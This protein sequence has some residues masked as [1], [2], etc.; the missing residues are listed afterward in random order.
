M[1][2]SSLDF[3]I[4]SLVIAL[5]VLWLTNVILWFTIPETNKYR[6]YIFIFSNIILLALFTM[7][8]YLGI[9]PTSLAIQTVGLFYLILIILLLIASVFYAVNRQQNPHNMPQSIQQA[10]AHIDDVIYPFYSKKE[11]MTFEDK[12]EAMSA[13]VRQIALTTV[14]TDLES[15]T[16]ISLFELRD[17]GKFR[18]LSTNNI[19]AHRISQLE[20]HFQYAPKSI[21][22]VGKCA[23]EKT[24]I[25]RSDLTN[26]AAR[27]DANW[28]PTPE[29]DMPHYSAKS[30]IC[31]PVLDKD[32]C[33]AVISIS[34]SKR[35]YFTTEHQHQL[36]RYASSARNLLI[37]LNKSLLIDP[38]EDY[39]IKAIT[40]S[41]EVGSG[42][43]TLAAALSYI[44]PSWRRVS[45]GDRF[46]R[47]CSDRGLTEQHINQ[48]PDEIHREFDEYQRLMLQQEE[49]IILESRLS[50]YLAAEMP[51]VLKIFCKLPLEQRIERTAQREDISFE[52]A[53]QKLLSRDEGDRERYRHLYGID[54][55]RI[56]DH[57][58]YL[59]TDG[60]PDSLARQVIHQ[61]RA[62]NRNKTS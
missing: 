22:T 60:S 18:I 23:L 47:F 61:I 40:I 51:D 27:R 24:P 62:N 28:E 14:P 34:S 32:K 42:K 1:T 50:G 55:Y 58:F 9:T 16:R 10:L 52:M 46:R 4:I 45:F 39:G 7:G 57:Y 17:N 26:D 19:D 41:G 44:L 59:N 54:D 36:E 48:V 38:D 49:K 5:A 8:V 43:T 21:G 29:N 56:G 30:I 13:I 33:L 11:E 25:L 12:R 2:T 3:N 37:M 15:L 53:R 35:N 6:I 20:E 31:V